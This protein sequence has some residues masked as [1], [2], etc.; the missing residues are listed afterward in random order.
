MA[1]QDPQST[2]D[3]IQQNLTLIGQIL[4]A[5][6]GCPDIGLVL[7]EML[8]TTEKLKTNCAMEAALKDPSWVLDDKLVAQIFP[9]MAVGRDLRPGEKLGDRSVI[10]R[11]FL[12]CLRL[13]V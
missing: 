11:E 1:D 6:G 7:S 8:E 9:E 3:Q 10:A 2:L 4:V 12:D 5:G 13:D